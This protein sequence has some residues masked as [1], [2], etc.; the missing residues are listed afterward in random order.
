MKEKNVTNASE[1]AYAMQ[2]CKLKSPL[3]R[4]HY[5]TILLIYRIINYYKFSV[6][7]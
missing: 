4:A 3:Y 6:S 7:G 2:S 5:K 1:I